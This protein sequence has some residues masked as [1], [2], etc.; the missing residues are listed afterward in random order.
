MV[1]LSAEIPRTKAHA[2][3]KDACAVAVSKDMSLIE[4]VKKLHAEIAPKNRIDWKA[5]AKPEN[6]PGQSEHFIDRVIESVRKGKAT[7]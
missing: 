6:Y 1:A 4:V 7:S 5:L 2:L 3:V